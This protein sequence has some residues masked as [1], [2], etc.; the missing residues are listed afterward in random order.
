[1][2]ATNTGDVSVTGTFLYTWEGQTI[3]SPPIPLESGQT[4]TYTTSHGTVLG[5]HTAEINVQWKAS[6]GSYD[7]VSTNSVAT[8]SVLVEANL[9]LVWDDDSIV[10]VDSKG[11]PATFP[12]NS[13]DTYT[14]L[15]YTSP[16]PRDATLSRMPSSA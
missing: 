7:R 3:E 5:Q 11:E 14:C 16:S 8:G 4:Y 15:L 13:G 1:M 2:T 12:L 6:S 10:I 9:Q